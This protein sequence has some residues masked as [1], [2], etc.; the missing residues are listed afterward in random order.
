MSQP[1]VISHPEPE[2]WKEWETRIIALKRPVIGQVRFTFV[3]VLDINEKNQD[4]EARIRL[5]CS[6]NVRD[7]L[8]VHPMR[9]VL[10]G[11]NRSSCCTV[12]Y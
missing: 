12:R 6:I 5:D 1:I 10:P 4:F 11:G 9:V 2:W 8:E 7:Q 3:R